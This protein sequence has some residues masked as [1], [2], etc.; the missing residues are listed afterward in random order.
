M[1][2]DFYLLFYSAFIFLIFVTINHFFYRTD[3]VY[4]K[5]FYFKSISKSNL[6]FIIMYI[7]WWHSIYFY[8]FISTY[9]QTD[10]N[11]LLTQLGYF[12]ILNIVCLMIPISKNSTWIN[13]YNISY[14]N[15]IYTH[16]M[17]SFFCFLSIIAK[18][19]VILINLNITQIK[20]MGAITFFLI[21]INIGIGLPYIKTKFNSVFYFLHRI[22]S[23]LILLFAILHNFNAIYYMIPSVL[24]Y[25]IDVIMRYTKTRESIYTSIKTIGDVDKN[26][27]SCIFVNITLI[28]SINVESGSYFF[29]H[30]NCKWYRISCITR[31]GDN[32]LFCI[33][34]KKNLWQ[35][36]NKKDNIET[37]A[38]YIQGP[39]KYLDIDYKKNQYE[40]VV[41]IADGTGITPII[42]IIKDMNDLYGDEKLDKMKKIF[43]I[44]V[45]EHSALILSYSYMFIPL[46]RFL[47][48]V[49]IISTNKDR[50][51][52]L[53]EN[54]YPI[55]KFDEKPNIEYLINSI[56][57]DHL[58][59]SN[60]TLAMFFGSL[61]VSQQVIKS[62]NKI[63]I[64]I[65]TK[66]SND[67]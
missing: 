25:I 24:F 2:S 40:Y 47:F 22:L 50:N 16:R 30:R 5:L 43:V 14:I 61:N 13:L 42:S 57:D 1:I 60:N 21:L 10:Y 62:F 48:N 34:N 37:S 41:A 51:S 4:V 7:I 45:V 65:Y 46:D 11:L 59:L 33:K 53:L 15:V 55:V 26:N 8:S 12:N 27:N 17:F 9:F 66:I 6:L 31:Y 29:I 36:D 64:P 35:L 38:M 44:W 54:V 63:N 52:I 18:T 28:K 3:Y 49:Q 67:F 39:Y 23:F 20:Y 58:L 32:L 19:T 56:I